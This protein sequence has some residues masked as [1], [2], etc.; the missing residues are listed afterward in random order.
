MDVNPNEVIKHLTN[1]ISRLNVELAILRAA[2]S[3]QESANGKEEE[4]AGQGS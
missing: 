2:L 3:Q 4:G 1:E